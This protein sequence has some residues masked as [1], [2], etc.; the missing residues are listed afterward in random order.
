MRHY[1]I[2]GIV[3]ALLSAVAYR[4]GYGDGRTEGA[5]QCIRVAHKIADDTRCTER[6]GV[7]PYTARNVEVPCP[8]PTPA[9]SSS[10]GTD[11]WSSVFTPTP[12]PSKTVAKLKIKS[13]EWYWVSASCPADGFPTIEIKPWEEK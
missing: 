2:A 11:P 6:V 1:I 4:I 9:H 8:T 7:F 5:A 13:G 3:T 12:A 10:F